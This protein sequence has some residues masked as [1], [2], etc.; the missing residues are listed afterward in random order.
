MTEKKRESKTYGWPLTAGL[1]F[2]FLLIFW[3]LWSL[4]IAGPSRIHEQVEAERVETIKAEVP[5]IEGLKQ[6]TFEYIT[7][8]GYTKDTLYWFDVTGKIITTREMKTLDYN[9]AKETAKSKYGID[10]S[11]IEL[12][13]GYN[14]P[15]YKIEGSG[16]MLLLD[17]DTMSKVYERS[18]EH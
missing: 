2:S 14:T 10:T 18:L 13:F 12:A 9:K 1:I 8:Q 6:N 15:V 17:Y 3:V 5:D 11:V 16:K 4:F 7:Y